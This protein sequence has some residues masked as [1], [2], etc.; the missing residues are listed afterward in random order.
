MLCNCPPPTPMQ[1]NLPPPGHHGYVPHTITFQRKR[2]NRRVINEDQM[3]KMLAE[4]GEVRP[5]CCWS[6]CVGSASAG[7]QASCTA[8]I[9]CPTSPSA[10]LLLTTKLRCTGWL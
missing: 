7:Q 2:A 1:Y 6:I 5:L 9:A 3:V 10:A 4:F 8:L